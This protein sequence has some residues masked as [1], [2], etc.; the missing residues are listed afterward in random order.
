M[1]FE[2]KPFPQLP[3]VVLVVPKVLGDAR[4]WFAE[5]YK[6]SDFD[7]AGIRGDFRQDN[8]SYSTGRGTL[9]GLH[10]QVD[11]MA[12]GKLV[13]VLRGEIFDVAVDIRR[14]APTYRTWV[15]ATL[16]AANHHMLWVPPGFA[17]GFQ[18]MTEETEVVYKTTNEY[19]P[20]HE[21]A[22]RWN[23]PAIGIAWPVVDAKLNA[24]DAAAPLLADAR[25]S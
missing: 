19:S 9:R 22:I 25:V 8:H 16:S 20:A 24:R 17:H 7:A 18:T 3:D 2:F 6:R 23:D 13:R 1:P 4:G 15:G 14:N 10:F 12:Q 21:G 5:T 11:P